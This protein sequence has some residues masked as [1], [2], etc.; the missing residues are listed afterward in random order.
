MVSFQRFIRRVLDDVKARRNLDSYVISSVALILLVLTLLPIDV[1]EKFITAVILAALCLLVLNI[2]SENTRA[3][4]LDDYLNDRASLGIFTE[5]I[6]GARK[7]WIYAPSAANVLRPE[8]ANAIRRE[9]LS[10]ADGE[11]RVIVQNPANEAAVDILIKQLDQGVDFQMQH[12]AEELTRMMHQ[13][14]LM[15]SWQVPGS[16]EYRL[17]DYG[18]GFSLVAVDPDLR[19]GQIIVEFHGFHHESVDK[20]MNIELTRDK[21]DRWYAYWMSQFEY[22]WERAQEPD[23]H[24]TSS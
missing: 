1:P 3:A 19:D 8:H 9:I 11:F 2:S 20:R 17:L 23:S 6:K 22:M 15:K 13:L 10:R 16:F 5:R 12:M 7:L 21:S 24:S 4:S 14:D 18:P